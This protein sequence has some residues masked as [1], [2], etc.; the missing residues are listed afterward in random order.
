MEIIKNFMIMA[1]YFQTDFTKMEK[2]KENQKITIKVV[3]YGL[4]NSI[5]MANYSAK[6]PMIKMEKLLKVKFTKV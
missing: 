3:K 5:K 4:F 1:L 6:P 2:Q